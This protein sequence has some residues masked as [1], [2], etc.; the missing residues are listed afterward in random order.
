M[1]WEGVS[2][3]RVVLLGTGYMTMF[4]LYK[5]IKLHTYDLSTFLYHFN[6]TLK[7]FLSL[8]CIIPSLVYD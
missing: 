5:F 8:Q 2:G 3:W 7:T 1:G 6:K 4:N